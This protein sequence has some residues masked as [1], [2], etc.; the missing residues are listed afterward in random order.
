MRTFVIGM[1]LYFWSIASGG[2]LNCSKWC[3]R[4]K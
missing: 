4:A 1:I 2:E 3:R